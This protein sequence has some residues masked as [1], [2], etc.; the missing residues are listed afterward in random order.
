MRASVH[1]DELGGHRPNRRVAAG[2]ELFVIVLA[3]GPRRPTAGSHRFVSDGPTPLGCRGGGSSLCRNVGLRFG[4]GL[5][6]I[7]LGV[8]ARE[9]EAWQEARPERATCRESGSAGELTRRRTGPNPAVK[10]DDGDGRE[11]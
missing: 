3:S 7:A 6:R 4:C 11:Q 1:G 9:R 5:L 8:E 10:P 2:M